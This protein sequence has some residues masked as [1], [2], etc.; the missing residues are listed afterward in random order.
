MKIY[1]TTF[2]ELSVALPE[3]FFVIFHGVLPCDDNIVFIRENICKEDIH[4]PDVNIS[5]G[6]FYRIIDDY[7]GCYDDKQAMNILLVT[8]NPRCIEQ[9][10]SVF[11]DLTFINLKDYE[12]PKIE[13]LKKY[14]LGI[15]TYAIWNQLPTG[16]I[17]SFVHFSPELAVRFKDDMSHFKLK[18]M[19]R[20]VIMGSNTF[21]S[22][23]CVPLHNRI[24]IVITH[25]AWQYKKCKISEFKHP[26]Y[27]KVSKLK[28]LYFVKSVDAAVKLG[29]MLSN[30]IHSKELYVIGG[31]QIYEQMWDYTDAFIISVTNVENK[32]WFV[33]ACACIEH[34]NLKSLDILKTEEYEYSGTL[35]FHGEAINVEGLRWQICTC[36]K[37]DEPK[38]PMFP[39]T[40]F[41]NDVPLIIK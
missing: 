29:L 15:K 37:S 6:A 22:M 10:K 35:F 11:K 36:V 41:N 32:K 4:I 25:N 16:E 34:D 39:F 40:C 24:N 21:K 23:N 12:Y 3:K 20:V 30:I 31:A 14:Y 1:H 9:F 17:G 27:S 38:I 2:S 19:G 18:T 5:P 26:I 13:E 7:R 33:N 28:N 8:S